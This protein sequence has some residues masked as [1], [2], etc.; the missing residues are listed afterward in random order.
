MIYLGRLPPSR[1]VHRNHI[2]CSGIW[3]SIF[4]E[5]KS[6]AIVSTIAICGGISNGVPPVAGSTLRGGAVW[7]FI[8]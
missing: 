1:G 8:E 3:P 2:A 6:F 4:W 7:I 5:F